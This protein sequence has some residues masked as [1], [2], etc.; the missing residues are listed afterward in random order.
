M[1]DRTQYFDQALVAKLVKKVRPYGDDQV[2]LMYERVETV[3][4][5]IAERSGLSF[6]DF[7]TYVEEN[8]SSPEFEALVYKLADFT[9]Q[10]RDKLCAAK[11]ELRP[12]LDAIY[13]L[14]TCLQSLDEF[15]APLLN[16]NLGKAT[17][18]LQ[19]LG[20]KVPVGF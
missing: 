6:S 1:A 14:R 18:D 17:C 20:I 19:H 9:D 8:T 5:H 2:A 11:E 3:L 16:N 12:Y 4:K 7:L 13:R 10:Q 15:G